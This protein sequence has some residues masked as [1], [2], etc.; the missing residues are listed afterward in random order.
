MN[1]ETRIKFLDSSKDAFKFLQYIL[2]FQFVKTYKET[3]I[4]VKTLVRKEKI[5]PLTLSTGNFL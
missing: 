5:L 4:E 3:H 1:Y 2:T